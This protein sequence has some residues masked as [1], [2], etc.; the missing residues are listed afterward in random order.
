MW[1]FLGKGSQ[2]C[3]SRNYNLQQERKSSQLGH[4][5]SNRSTFKKIKQ[6]APAPTILWLLCLC[7]ILW[8]AFYRPREACLGCPNYFWGYQLLFLLVL[9][10][11]NCTD[12]EWS[13]PQCEVFY[14]IAHTTLWQK[15]LCTLARTLLIHVENQEQV[16]KEAH[17]HFPKLPFLSTIMIGLNSMLFSYCTWGPLNPSLRWHLSFCPQF[18]TEVH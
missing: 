16:S 12:F 2:N 15:H 3:S 5:A 17:Q 10:L 14:R 6:Q 8:G 1:F 4:C 7:N 13:V 18:E 9:W 11:Q